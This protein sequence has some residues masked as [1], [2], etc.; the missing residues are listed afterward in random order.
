MSRRDNPTGQHG[1]RERPA[2][3]AEPPP[4]GVA[5]A[6]EQAVIALLRAAGAH[7]LTTPAQRARIRD[8]VLAR[9]AGH[10]SAA[11]NTPPADTPTDTGAPA[12]R[13]HP[14]KITPAGR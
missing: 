5:P 10:D 7:R 12:A 3:A 13:R 14:D 6:G 1:Q 4:P 11:A 9:L 8:A 2:R